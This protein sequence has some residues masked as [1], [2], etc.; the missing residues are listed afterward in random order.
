MKTSSKIFFNIAIFH[1]VLLFV[2]GTSFCVD[3]GSDTAPTRFSTQQ[4]L[5]NGDRVAGFASLE[6]GFRLIGSVATATFDS[7]FPV[8]GDIELR[9]GALILDR[10]LILRNVS[11]FITLGD[12][13]GNGH[14]LEF[15][16]TVTILPLGDQGSGWTTAGIVPVSNPTTDV[17]QSRQLALPRKRLK[18]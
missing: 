14:T 3:I 6:A 17:G 16:P 10:D 2:T 15:S 7:F 13:F 8:S 18:M 9:F 11:S 4:T 1:S 5:W 12:I